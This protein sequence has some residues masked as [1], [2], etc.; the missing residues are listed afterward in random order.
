MSSCTSGLSWAKL[1]ALSEVLI[2]PVKQQQQQQKKKVGSQTKHL[3]YSKDCINVLSYQK[4][5]YGGQRII[6][7]KHSE[8]TC[9]LFGLAEASSSLAVRKYFFSAAIL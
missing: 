9:S 2:V 3:F 5:C 6:E 7:A 4:G 1:Q 8:N